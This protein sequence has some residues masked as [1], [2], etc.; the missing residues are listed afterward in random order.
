ML[1]GKLRVN[2]SYL[3]LWILYLFFSKNINSFVE[4]NVGRVVAF[5]VILTNS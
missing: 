5:L 3:L 1:F 4:R 2:G